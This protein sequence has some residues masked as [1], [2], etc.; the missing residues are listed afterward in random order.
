M[1]QLTDYSQFG[2]NEDSLDLYWKLDNGVQYDK[3]ALLDILEDQNFPHENSTSR[4]RLQELYTRCQ[5]KLMSYEDLDLPKLKICIARRGL[6]FPPE[7]DTLSSLKAMLEHV[8]EKATF[9]RFC[10]LPSELRLQ[11]YTHH[12]KSFA[13]TSAKIVSQPPITGVSRQIREE[14]LP[15][16]YGCCNFEVSITS[17]ED[18]SGHLLHSGRPSR[19]LQRTTSEQF[20]WIRNINVD[21]NISASRV[22]L[23]LDLCN[24]RN[25]VKISRTSSVYFRV[26]TPECVNDLT[27]E[28]DSLVRA[29]AAPQRASKLQK[30]DL[31][32]LRGKARAIINQ[33]YKRA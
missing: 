18:L 3:D 31:D 13:G 30:S 5:R 11:I 23:E 9:H 6:S 2:Q 32:Q 1:V 33:H 15:V 10:D 25:P 27:S 22:W 4:A 21:F 8:D 19:L 17:F 29:I 16:F 24:K 28:L 12:F 20:G 14:S 7:K 26:F